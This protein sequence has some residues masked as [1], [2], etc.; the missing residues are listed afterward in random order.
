MTMFKWM[1]ACTAT[2]LLLSAAP[3]LAA[4]AEG[5]L[6]VGDKAPRLADVTWVKG[7][8][9]AE[10]QA[11][12]VYVLDFW[13][14]WCGPC[15]A[16]IPH[17]NELSK[18]YANDDVRVIGVAIWPRPGMVPTADFVREQGDEMSYDIAADV[19][20]RTAEAFMRASLS[21]GIP[22]VMI[23]NRAGKLAWVG[24]PIELDEPLAQIVAGEADMDALAAADKL[25][26]D[27]A[28]KEAA[29]QEAMAKIVPRLNAAYE[30]KDWPGALAALDELLKLDEANP[31]FTRLKYSLLLK[32]GDKQ[33]AEQYGTGLVVKTLHES[34]QGLNELAWF[35]VDP[36]GDV[37]P[38]ERDLALALSAAARADE[39][40][41]HKDASIID[42]LARVH[43][44]KG[45]VAK[46]IEL[47][48]QAL[49]LASSEQR[50]QLQPA[51]DEY[52]KAAAAKG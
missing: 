51:L 48:K 16:T 4:S 46:A 45:D 27:T 29:L 52:T 9:V 17:V 26:R 6:G 23:V 40:S 37:A 35:I 34:A 32:S 28:R 15:K 14:T 25:R 44:Y 43:F 47:Q 33:R 2:L 38:E 8:P 42:T 5:E 21:N 30:A 49:E 13:A 10:W 36:E 20:E 7:A 31:N 3:A 39:L 12:T 50:P 19:G 24:H 11:G 41:G 18:K 1:A 22:T